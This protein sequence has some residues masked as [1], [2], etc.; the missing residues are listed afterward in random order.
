MDNNK[1]RK[2]KIYSKIPFKDNN[3]YY[4]YRGFFYNKFKLGY[5]EL[6]NFLLLGNITVK[7]GSKKYTK[8]RNI[9]MQN[10]RTVSTRM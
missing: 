1:G 6:T 9:R 2:N 10:K 3:T 5:A 7:G 4:I 8:R